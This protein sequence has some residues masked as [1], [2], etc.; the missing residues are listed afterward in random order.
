MSF[1][2]RPAYCQAHAG[3]GGLCGEKRVVNSCLMALTDAMTA[4]VE[5]LTEPERELE[6]GDLEV[7]VLDRGNGRRAFRRIEGEELAALIG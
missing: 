6:V 3:A 1:Q 7:A 2:Q 5:A 4:A